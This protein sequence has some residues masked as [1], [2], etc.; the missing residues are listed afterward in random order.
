[1]FRSFPSGCSVA[2]EIQDVSE[3]LTKQ[4]SVANRA[5]SRIHF[6]LLYPFHLILHN[7]V[8]CSLS[9]KIKKFCFKL[10]ADRLRGFVT[11]MDFFGNVYVFITSLLDFLVEILT[12]RLYFKSLHFVHPVSIYFSVSL[13]ILF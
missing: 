12:V 11:V 13:Y 3:I 4:N 9:V 7:W 1:M 8:P 2:E 10:F 5:T 6:F